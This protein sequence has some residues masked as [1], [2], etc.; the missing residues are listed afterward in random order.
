MGKVHNQSGDIKAAIK[1]YQRA[2]GLKPDLTE[3]RDRLRQALQ[4]EDGIK[5]KVSIAKQ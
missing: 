1:Y 4:E 3:V 2:I 5:I